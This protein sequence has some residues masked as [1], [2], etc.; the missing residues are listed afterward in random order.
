[1]SNVGF[2][3]TWKRT[4]KGR[5]N[6]HCRC[7]TRGSSDSRRTPVSSARRVVHDG[8]HPRPL[9]LKA[10]GALEKWTGSAVQK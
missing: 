3:T 7:A 2:F 9:Q 8:H 1:L 5:L 4:E 6:V 10:L